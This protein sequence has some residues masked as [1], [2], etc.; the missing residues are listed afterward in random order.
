MVGFGSFLGVFSDVKIH[1][2]TGLSLFLNVSFHIRFV[3]EQ[4]RNRFCFFA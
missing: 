1:R 2:L 3:I 4:S